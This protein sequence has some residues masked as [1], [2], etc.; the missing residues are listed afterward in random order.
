MKRN[1]L[2]MPRRQNFEK[3]LI[4]TR[5]IENESGHVFHFAK[6]RRERD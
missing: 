4:L 1:S 6:Q 5:H 3:V 2:K